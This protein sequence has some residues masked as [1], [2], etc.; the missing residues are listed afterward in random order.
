MTYST[1]LIERQDDVAVVTLNRPDRLNAIDAAMFVEIDLALLELE[2]DSETRAIVLTG[3]GRGFS[4]GLDLQEVEE[5]KDLSV[6]EFF[7]KQ[8]NGARSLTR[9]REITTPVIAAVNGPAS[10]GGLALALAADVRFASPEAFFNVAFVRIGLTGGDMGVSWALPRIVGLGHAADMMLTGRRVDAE[11]AARVGL[12]NRVV[13]GEQLLD[14]AIAYARLITANSPF[15]I[16]LTK[17]VLQ[18]SVDAPSLQAAIAIENRQQALSARS[19]DHREAVHAFL[20]KRP[21]KFSGE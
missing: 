16:A 6:T 4:A 21:A 5:L 10:G 11:E 9:A 13:P 19:L 8:A 18:M 17:E 12:V 3:A 1:L 2:A 14:E 15:G 20:E 7:A